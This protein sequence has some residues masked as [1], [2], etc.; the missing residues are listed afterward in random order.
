MFTR[1]KGNDLVTK[2]PMASFVYHGVYRIILAGFRH[3]IY[4][5]IQYKISSRPREAYEI[6]YNL[7]KSSDFI[8]HFFV[9]RK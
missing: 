2:K 7:Y 8:Q 1:T 6:L 3:I 4:Y 5:N 9:V